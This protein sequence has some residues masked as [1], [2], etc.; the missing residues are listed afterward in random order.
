MH[1]YIFFVCFFFFKFFFLLTLLYFYKCSFCLWW[2]FL[3]PFSASL[4]NLSTTLWVTL[5]IN[6]H[7]LFSIKWLTKFCQDLVPKIS[8]LICNNLVHTKSHKACGIR[9]NHLIGPISDVYLLENC[10]LK[11]FVLRTAREGF[12]DLS[13]VSVYQPL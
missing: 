2:I 12:V 7:W 13:E 8:T 10:T 6:C 3:F 4:V 11:P 1:P 9:A 5:F